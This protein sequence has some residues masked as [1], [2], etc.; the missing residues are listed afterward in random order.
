MLGIMH[1]EYAVNPVKKEPVYKETCIK[2][3]KVMV[4]PKRILYN[5]VDNEFAKTPT[6]QKL[7]TFICLAIPSYL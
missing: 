1:F 4:P 7:T 6:C 3:K 2:Q 5:I